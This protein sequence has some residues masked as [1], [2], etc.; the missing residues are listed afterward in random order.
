M[1][2]Y[3]I[4]E[5]LQE[6]VEVPE[7][8]QTKAEEALE[9]IR[10]TCAGG[11][12]KSPVGG[13]GNVMSRRGRKRLIV[14]IAAAVLAI[15]GTC[16]AATYRG[17]SRSTEKQMNISEKQKSEF[18]SQA[19]EK[20]DKVEAQ[21]TEQ[22][23]VQEM[24]NDTLVT[25]PEVSATDK[26]VTIT[27]QDCIVDNYNARLSFRVEGYQ[28]P[29]APEGMAS[30]QPELKFGIM[31]DGEQNPGDIS[32]SF[33]SGWY[34]G[35]FEKLLEDE[36]IQNYQFPDGSMEYNIHISC[37][38]K[39]YYMNKPIRVAFSGFEYYT[40]K[41]GE[42]HMD[43]EGNW[44]LEWTL[45]GS[46]E[47]YEADVEHGAIGDTGATL[48]HVELSPISAKVLVHFPKQEYEEETDD[49]GIHTTWKEPPRLCGVKLSDGTV[50]YDSWLGGGGSLCYVETDIC[51]ILNYSG[52]IVDVSQVEY[53]LFQKDYPE[54]GNVTDDNFYFVKVR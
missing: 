13:K 17:F 16:V 2:M 37:I 51:E 34:G 7:I 9:Q 48:T 29:E 32:G 24:E 8:V 49:G 42:P 20:V 53:L 26:G 1:N 41:A 6:D 30:C 44:A 43:L 47:V 52:Q 40:E 11:K 31:V 12:K 23:R 28:M 25:F 35:A 27:L 39:G 3:E 15:G 14:S 4:I 19:M 50:S 5:A 21:E 22:E 36:T 45:R 38:D 33:Y 10:K 18:E 54:D 46:D